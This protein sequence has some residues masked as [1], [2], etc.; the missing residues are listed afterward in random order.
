VS[1]TPRWV[2]DSN[3]IVSAFLWHGRPGE[4]LTLAGDGEIKLYASRELLAEVASTL[5][6]PRLAT[7]VAATGRSIREMLADYRRLVAIVRAK[8]LETPLSRDPDDDAI[9]ACALAA[10]ADVIVSGDKDLLVLREVQGIVIWKVTD[11]VF[12]IDRLN[13]KAHLNP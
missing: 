12:A 6:K 3:V 8:P 11:A 1:R 7:A 2:L 5:S 4:I 9:I 10:R 13:G